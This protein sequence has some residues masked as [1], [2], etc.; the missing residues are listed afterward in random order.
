MKQ[1]VA[2]AEV[3]GKVAWETSARP[4][5]GTSPILGARHVFTAAAPANVVA[6]F[7]DTAR[8][9]AAVSTA[10][11]TGR[12][13]YFGFLPGLSYFLPAIPKRPADRG[14][15]DASFTHFVPSEFDWSILDLL[16]SVISPTYSRQVECSNNLVHGRPVVAA[17]K[18]IVVPLVNWS[19]EEM[20][21]SL[22]V[23]V[24]LGSITTAMKATMASGAAVVTHQSSVTGV[25]VYIVSEFSVA[26]ALILRV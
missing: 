20:I 13:M 16:T 8:S 4:Y 1:D 15:T 19:G 25:G 23:T 22:N 11:G 12:T 21:A 3:L 9:A 10:V 5:V 26:D 2:F 18:G 24:R 14:G 17:G 7:D 6:T